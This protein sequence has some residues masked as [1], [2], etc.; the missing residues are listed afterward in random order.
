MKYY[1][2]GKPG[3]VP[4]LLN[5]R[6]ELLHPHDQ[7]SVKVHEFDVGTP[8]QATAYFNGY[9]ARWEETAPAAARSRYRRSS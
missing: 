2:W 7:G 1:I 3:E 5:D 4:D 6:E 9:V 8:A